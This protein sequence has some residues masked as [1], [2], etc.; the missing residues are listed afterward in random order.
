MPDRTIIQWDKDDLETLGLLKVDCLALGML[1]CVSKCLA[2]L[3]RH[4]GVAHTPASLPADDAPTYAMIQ[5]ADTIGVFQIESRA[6]MGML[7]RM[8]PACFYDLVIEVALVRPGPIQGK[9]VHPY[10][11]R[12]QGKDPV[13]YPSDDLKVVFERTLGIPLFQE[14][15]MHLAI[16]AA[17]FTPGEADKLRRAMA[18]W[19]RRGG[20][21]IYRAR[22]LE[23]MAANGYDTAFAEQV[24]EQIKGFGSY[25]FPES[26]AASFALITYVSCW[27][28][29]HYPAAFTCA[30][31]NS[32]PL[33]FYSPNQ[34]VQDLRRHG[35]E[36]RPVD[37]RFS[38]WDAALEDV[39]GA[40]LSA[41]PL[42]RSEGGGW[43]G[44]RLGSA[45][46]SRRSGFT[47]PQPSSSL[48]EREGARTHALRLGLREIRGLSHDA[49]QRIET[50]RATHPFESI[51]DLCLRADLDARERSLL[52][53]AGALRGLSGHR[54]RARWAIQG[55]ERQ[56]P[57]FDG[58]PVVEDKVALPVPTAGEDAKADYARTGLTLGPHPLAL[59]RRQLAARRCRRSR[60]FAALAH[61]TP[62]R[63]AGLVTLRQRPETAAGVTFVTLEDEDG[64]VNVVVWRDLAE[65]QR[66]VLLESR[67]L[68][69][70]GRLESADGVQH[71]IAGR[72]EDYSPLLGALDVRSRDFR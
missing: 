64:L 28:K 8:K 10:L 5:R 21:E 3:Q 63:L 67:L 62:V 44:V 42:S 39:R 60:E 34:L 55:V 24:F 72:L 26:H 50:A 31:L 47:P 17:G 45:V 35:H 38:G 36:V 2:L 41:P 33:G 15:V 66:R 13:V 19:K 6:Q 25:G 69:V 1:T 46:D 18:A 37:V 43:E 57:L 23:G 56:L 49:A 65:R 30:L 52:A 29:C 32:Q 4:Y 54:H 53:D 22:I 68:A 40:L 58:V 59:I 71:L 27:L 51:E 16:V 7:P 12:R 61:G 20:L 48:R 11:R 70:E 9:M 14:Q